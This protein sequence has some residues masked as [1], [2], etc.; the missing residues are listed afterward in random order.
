MHPRTVAIVAVVVLAAAIGLR[1]LVVRYSLLPVSEEA[2]LKK[3]VAITVGYYHHGSFKKLQITDPEQV[4]D[5]LG[6]LRIVDELGMARN[7]GS[8]AA[9]GSLVSKIPIEFHFPQGVT[10]EYT[11]QKQMLG[12]FVVDRDFYRKLNEIASQRVGQA[13]DILDVPP[14]VE[15]NKTAPDNP[16]KDK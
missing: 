10:R 2:V 6:T 15:R 11:L 4:Q 16:G 14:E 3:A 1:V 13:I 12:G 7:F 8:L 9:Q 5:V